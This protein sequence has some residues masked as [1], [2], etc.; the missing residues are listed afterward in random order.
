MARLEA[1]RVTWEKVE[2]FGKECLFTALRIDRNSIPKGYTM[3]EIRH[4]DEDWGEP[5]EIAFGVL[6]NFFGTLL[7]KE[8]FE[9]ESSAV[10]DNAYMWIEDG[11]WKYLDE[12]VTL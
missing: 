4:R 6:V 10:T 2:V 12:M 9:L 8:E 7:S 3:Y 11:E 5:I 1:N